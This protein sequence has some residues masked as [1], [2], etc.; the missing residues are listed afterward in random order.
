MYHM[1]LTDSERVHPLRL[2]NEAVDF[3]HLIKAR[4]RPTFPLNNLFHF[5]SERLHIFRTGSQ[6]I[7]CMRETLPQI[8]KNWFAQ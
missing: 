3:V 7:E 8:F 5:F 1:G 2:L 4:L 6:T